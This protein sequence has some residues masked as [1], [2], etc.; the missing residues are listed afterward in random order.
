MTINTHARLRT[1]YGEQGE[2]IHKMD[3]AL[4]GE[5]SPPEGNP[6]GAAPVVNASDAEGQLV[7][8]GDIEIDG[9]V[10]EIDAEEES[11]EESAPPVASTGG[12]EVEIADAAPAK[13]TAAAKKAA[14]PK[15]DS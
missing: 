14:A 10:P 3:P 6:A 2:H 4:W 1:A 8:T 7:D 12:A 11:E 13:K 5:D 15:S 9:P